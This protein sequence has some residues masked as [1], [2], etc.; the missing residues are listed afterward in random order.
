MSKTATNVFIPSSYSVWT[1]P[2]GTAAPT[3]PTATPSASWYEV[4]FLSDQGITE[5]RD[6]NET[7][8]YDMVGALLAVARNQEKRPF[9]FEGLEDN[10]VVREL[11]YPGSTFSSSGGTAE[12]QTATVTGTPTGG[13]FT[14][15]G[16]VGGTGTTTAIAYNATS[17]TVQTA[18]QALPG[19]S[20]ATVAGSAGGPY[21]ITYPATLGDVPQLTAN[22]SALTGGSSPAVNV[23]TTTP[24]TSPVNTRN[25][26]SGTGQNLR[27]FLIYISKG[28]KHKLFV[29]NNGEATQSGTVGYTGSGAAVSQFTLQP[30]L[31][32]NGNFFQLLD[33]DPAQNAS[34]N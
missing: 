32:S 33:D 11:R 29:I 8:I 5:G 15:T 16:G 2:L 31:D 7:D 25:V 30:F 3:T 34:Y 12:V 10:R 14:L 6:I 4:G 20:A 17:A 18:V 9:T 13:T 24:G 1:A 26:G 28:S 21:T 23:A 19:L 22:S 27:A